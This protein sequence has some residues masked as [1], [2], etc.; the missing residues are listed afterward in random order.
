MRQST[1]RQP[2]PSEL[3]PN[4]TTNYHYANGAFRALPFH[5]LRIPATGEGHMTVTD[6]AQFMIAH[7]QDGDSPI[8]KAAAARQMHS[9]LFVHDPRVS[10]IAYGFAE[11]TQNGLRLL[12]HEGNLEGVSSTAL[13]L[14]PEQQLGVY[15]VFNSNGGFGPGEQFRRAFLDHYFPTQA[16][17]PR[18][19]D[20]TQQQVTALTGSYGST[21]M[22]STSFGKILR[23]LGGNYADVMVSANPDG[24]FT[25]HGIGS[26]ALQWVAVEPQV[27]RPADGALNAQGD[28]VFATDERGRLTRLFVGNNPYRA[29]EKV[30]WYETVP[31]QT[32]LVSLSEL[33]FLLAL[34]ALPLGR[35]LRRRLPAAHVS[36][37]NR[38]VRW[39]LGGAC[40]L[41][42]AFPVGLMLTL[43]EALLY[44][45]TPALI[46]VL[47][48][49]LLAIALAGG[50]FFLA[51]RGWAALGMAGRIH[52]AAVMA[53]MVTF[54]GWLSY[55]NLLGWRF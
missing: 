1:F 20:L 53:A 22:F 27:L 8:L 16:I 25:T 35:L 55:W 31:F 3:A 18:A 17:P 46:A 19:A 32:I 14:I 30:A 10:G 44:G 2:L 43:G 50:A 12:R 42:L 15:V 23:L 11:T 40:V 38:V 48:L 51:L 29:Y 41:A 24:T 28:L 54:I 33:V 4:V 39:L 37:P 13:F 49:P 9:Q 34:I 21:R 36:A 6:M 26:T 45:V 47:S 52:H 7:L 5:Y